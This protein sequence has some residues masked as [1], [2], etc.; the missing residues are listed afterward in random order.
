MKLRKF[1]GITL[2]ALATKLLHWIQIIQDTIQ[3]EDPSKSIHSEEASSYPLQNEGEIP[4]AGADAPKPPVEWVAYIKKKAPH[5]L[6]TLGK[7]MTYTASPKPHV[8]PL[9]EKRQKS[10]LHQTIPPT[11]RQ[12]ESSTAPQPIKESLKSERSSF[13]LRPTE[14]EPIHIQPQGKTSPLEKNTQTS[15]DKKEKPFRIRPFT[16]EEIPHHPIK[17]PSDKNQTVS[18]LPLQ[19]TPQ[20]TSQ[21]TSPTKKTAILKKRIQKPVIQKKSP[22]SLDKG[23]TNTVH[24]TPNIQYTGPTTKKPS[25]AQPI[26]PIHFTPQRPQSFESKTPPEPKVE[27]QPYRSFIPQ[28]P[29]SSNLEKSKV[30]HSNIT[31]QVPQ[32]ST[33]VIPAKLNPSISNISQEN[34][35]EKQTHRNEIHPKPNLNPSPHSSREEDLAPSLPQKTGSTLHSITSSH[36]KQPEGYWPELPAL[37]KLE[38][39]EVNVYLNNKNRI[40]KLDIE[41]KG[42]LWNA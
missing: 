3:K 7:G 29:P 13:R 5:L 22:S 39:S 17:Q 28:D 4:A 38:E 31:Q 8:T 27:A 26:P 35:G 16:I 33:P 20:H 32:P 42:E 37:D 14:P 30:K 9:P 6:P 21:K 19:G 25:Q 2:E 11:K 12:R 40:E 18:S 23:D 15:T 1:I 41:Q 10:P 36:S 24:D 34:I